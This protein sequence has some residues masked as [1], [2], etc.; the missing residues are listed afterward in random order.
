ML[1]ILNPWQRKT[2]EEDWGKSSSVTSLLAKNNALCFRLNSVW[3]G[4]E[5]EI[6]VISKVLADVDHALESI[7]ASTEKENVICINCNPK[8]VSTNS[9]SQL[10]PS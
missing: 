8:I 4:A 2:F 9:A 10:T 1:Q 5:L 7:S 3:V 6:E